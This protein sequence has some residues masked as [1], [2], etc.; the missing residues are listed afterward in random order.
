MLPKLIL[1]SLMLFAA[2][3][4]AQPGPGWFGDDGFASQPCCTVVP[5]SS[6]NIPVAPAFTMNGQYACIRDCNIE[7]VFNVQVTVQDTPI[8][9]DYHI[10]PLTVSPASPGG[11]GY[12]T[13]LI[14]KYARTWIEPSAS[15]ALDRQVWRWIVNADLNVTAG[16][17]PCPIP[18]TAAV[19][20]PHFHGHIDFACEPD[21]FGLPMWECA[22]SLSHLESCI[23]HNNFSCVPVPIVD[24][25]AF[26]LVASSSA[27][28]FFG[29]TPEP[30]GP[31]L[32]E[33]F[34]S[35]LIPPFQCLGEGQI[36][37]G[38]LNTQFYSCVCNPMM[39]PAPFDYAH[40]M[41]NASVQCVG[42]V[43]P[44]NSVPLAAPLPPLPTG[45]I[46]RP[47]GRWTGPLGSFPGPRELTIHWGLLSQTDPCN[48]ADL[49]FHFV[50]GVSTF[51]VDG[52][53]FN[54]TPVTPPSFTVFTDL[55]DMLVPNPFVPGTFT[56][57]FGCLHLPKRV[58]NLNIP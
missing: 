20:P 22:L 27:P 31:I 3:V 16:S 29:P 28:F 42:A 2:S 35:S 7:Q 41:L 58:W 36:Q 48:T 15:G 32:G 39:P 12:A 46:S 33:S 43:F 37:Q 1:S 34:R 51:G 6:V 56:I 50:Q 53:V 47:L 19:Y 44:F 55:A 23:E 8:L 10:M 49:P 40:Q 45:F 26:H 17:A 18:V 57:G 30:M 38:G 11:P 5:F 24:N 9:C 54:P 13:T 52:F 4:A 25:R 14:G 21:P